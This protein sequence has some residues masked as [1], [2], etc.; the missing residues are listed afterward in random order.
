MAIKIFVCLLI[1]NEHGTLDR[2]AVYLEAIVYK[3][4][5]LNSKFITLKQYIRS[6]L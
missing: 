3:N 5:V 1:V 4:I 2:S 6:D